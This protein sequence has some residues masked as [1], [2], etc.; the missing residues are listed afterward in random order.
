MQR[1]TARCARCGQQALLTLTQ[2]RDR[3]RLKHLFGLGDYDPRVDRF[4]SCPACG[5][6]YPTSSTSLRAD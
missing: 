6:K 5:K 4:I 1:A 3:R 2:A